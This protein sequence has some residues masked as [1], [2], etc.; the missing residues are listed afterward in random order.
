MHGGAEGAGVVRCRVVVQALPSRQGVFIVRQECRDDLEWTTV[1]HA[2]SP[3][4]G[5]AM[6]A[7]WYARRFNEESPLAFLGLEILA[8]E[9]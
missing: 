5:A 7:P 2:V 6:G 1:A 9:I 3:V 4:V 8:R